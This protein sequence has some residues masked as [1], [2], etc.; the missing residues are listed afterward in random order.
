M[1]TLLI[2]GDVLAYKVAASMETPTDWGDGIWTLHADENEGKQ[3]LCYMI[4][5]LE[6]DFQPQDV[7]IALSSTS[8]FRKDILPSYKSNRDGIRKPMILKPLREYLIS[9]FNAY[10]TVGLEADDLIGLEATCPSTNGIIISVDKDFNQIP[11]KF[12][13]LKD[14]DRG[15]MTITQRQADYWHLYQTLIGDKTDGY[16]G[17]P[18]VGPKKAEAILSSVESKDDKEWVKLS[19]VKVLEAFAKADLGPEEALVQA[20]VARILRYEDYDHINEKPILWNPPE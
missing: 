14:P 9:T 11:G 10:F 1:T 5:E 12:F 3:L 7:I 13:D 8:N 20:R 2:D 18:G 15:V 19:W 17:C 16:S 6:A 4:R